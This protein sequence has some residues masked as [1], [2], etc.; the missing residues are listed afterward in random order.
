MKNQEPPSRLEENAGPHGP[1]TKDNPIGIDDIGLPSG[2]QP[3]E[4][5]KPEQIKPDPGKTQEKR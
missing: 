5:G 2:I 1:R 3:D 4:V